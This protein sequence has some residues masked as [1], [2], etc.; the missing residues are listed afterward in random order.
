MRKVIRDARF[1]DGRRHNLVIENGVIVELTDR[2][3]TGAKEI[4]LP[5]NV[6]VSPGWIDLHVHAFPKFKPYCSNPDEIGYPTGVTTIIDAGSSGADDI[7]EFFQMASESITNVLSIINISRIGLK[8]INE[9]ADLENISYTA[10]ERAVQNHPDK[11]VGLKARMSG[12]VVGGNGVI[13]LDLAKEYGSKLNLPVMVHIGNAPPLLSEILKRLTAGD[14]I[15]HCYNDK[16]NNH[17]FSNGNKELLLEAI[18]KGVYLD[19]GHG[20]ASFSFDIAKRAKEENIAFDTIST[21]IYEGNMKNGPV[22]NM[23]R[24]LTKFLSL[25]YSLEEVIKA[26]TEVPAKIINQPELGELKIGTPADLTFFTLEE[27]S[28]QL[29]DSAGKEL[30]SSVSI[31]PHSVLIGGNYYVCK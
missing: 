19:V 23:A 17:I 14:I 10:L 7:D 11:I 6:Y 21:D 12:S 8:S 13:P 26:V 29:I 3:I 16:E 9:L 1:I 24:T 2:H 30:Q 20:S 25:G 15:T 28:V 22:Y 31:K 4:N 27:E 18:N 5:D